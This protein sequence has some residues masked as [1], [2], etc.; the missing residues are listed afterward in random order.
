MVYYF[1][2][3]RNVNFQKSHKGKFYM[4]IILSYQH[5]FFRRAV[6]Y[7]LQLLKT[8]FKHFI[9]FSDKPIPLYDQKQAL[10]VVQVSGL[11]L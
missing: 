2:C 5:V 11:E 10:Y 7:L 8:T 4:I 1:Q 3:I 6:E 9:L